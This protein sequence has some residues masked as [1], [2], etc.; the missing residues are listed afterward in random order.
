[1]GIL[2]PLVFSLFFYRDFFLLGSASTRNLWSRLGFYAANLLGSVLLAPMIISKFEVG[3]IHSFTF[4]LFCGLFYSVLLGLCFWL[5]RYGL[6]DFVWLTALPN[7]ALIGSIIIF[8]S[9]DLQDGTQY[10][11]FLVLAWIG[12]MSVG[13]LATTSK[14][15]THPESD[16]SLQ[17]AAVM[18]L[19]ATVIL[20]VDALLTHANP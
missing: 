20:P 16:P 4:A 15:P 5:R 13:L 7:P 3:W 6:Y 8:A 14:T 10:S 2:I 17:L 9:T 11:V 18:N 1:M 19:M 12:A